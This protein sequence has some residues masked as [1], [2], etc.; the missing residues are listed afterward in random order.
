M[1]KIY[2]IIAVVVLFFAG[3]RLAGFILKKITS[4]SQFRYSRLYTDRAEADILLVGNSR[5]LIF[6]QPYIEEKTGQST[7]NISYNGMPINLARVLVEDYYERYDAPELL[8]LDVTMA[9]RF[10]NALISDFNTYTPYS[11]RLTKLI[12]DSIP[13]AGYGGQLT[14]LYRYNSEVF[15]RALFYYNRTDEDWLLDRRI[16]DHMI[17][18]VSSS[19][20]LHFNF[21]GLHPDIKSIIQLAESKG[22]KVE[23]VVNPYYPPFANRFDGFDKWV[24]SIEQLTGKPIKNYA[25]SVRETDA[26]GD[27]Q[28]LNKLGARLFIDRLI[29]DGVLRN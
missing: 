2:W 29:K 21:T 26:F 5:G 18:N 11:E 1:K 24:K 14:H 25:S 4:N 6:Y 12:V 9:D 15:Q 23:L 10:N 20:S 13:T 16:N 8:V 27:Y 22:T 17:D 3:D 28:H 19:D 7:F